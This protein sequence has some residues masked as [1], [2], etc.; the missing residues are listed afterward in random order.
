MWFPEEEGVVQVEQ[1]G[2]HCRDDGTVV[3][4][5]EIDAIM[6][7]D[8]EHVSLD[9]LSRLLVDIH[10]DS[11]RILDSVISNYQR[12]LLDL[13]FVGDAS[14]RDK[15][16]VILAKSIT[17]KLPAAKYVLLLYL[18]QIFHWGASFEGII[19]QTLMQRAGTWTRRRTKTS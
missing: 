16:N 1:F 14:S 13:L 4:G 3:C 2:V 5:L 8:A 19:S 9:L 10:V 7:N 6:A 17:P 11:S 18:I 15:F 12:S